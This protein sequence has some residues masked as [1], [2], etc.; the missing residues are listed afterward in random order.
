M[1]GVDFG[2][3]PIQLFRQPFLRYFDSAIFEVLQSAS[4]YSM[5]VITGTW[6]WSRGV[7]FQIPFNLG[8]ASLATNLGNI[9]SHLLEAQWKE[10]SVPRF[11]VRVAVFLPS[12]ARW[13][14]SNKWRCSPTAQ[15]LMAKQWAACSNYELANGSMM[16]QRVGSDTVKLEK[17][18]LGPER[19]CHLEECGKDPQTFL[20]R[21]WCWSDDM[22]D[23]FN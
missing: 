20:C 1:P 2:S 16:V 22:I 11:K 9:S 8:A 12:M 19:P 6:E 5:M 10:S 14:G 13:N 15:P 7:H 18:D 3:F 23:I 21:I 17:R 4:T